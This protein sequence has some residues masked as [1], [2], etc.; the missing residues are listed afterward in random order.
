MWDQKWGLN[1]LRWK[2]SWMVGTM[3]KVL[4]VGIHRMLRW[5]PLRE[6]RIFLRSK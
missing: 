5:G 4:V 3:I 6:M 2:F 1:L